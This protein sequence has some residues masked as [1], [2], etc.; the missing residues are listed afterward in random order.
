LKNTEAEYDKQ[1]KE[2]K[3]SKDKGNDFKVSQIEHKRNQALAKIRKEFAE[4]EEQI[5]AFYERINQI[6]GKL[7]V[8]TVISEDEYT[9]L[10]E[11]GLIFFEAMM[12]AEAVKRLLE[13]LDL[14]KE[15]RKLRMKADKEKGDKRAKT[16]RRIQYLEG[17]QNNTIQ[18]NLDGFE[19]FASITSR[20]KAN[21]SS[22]RR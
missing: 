5:D 10:I 7:K 14:Q 4:R 17:F 21:N 16:T 1:L 12:G 8:G 13:R 3:K 18:S 15:L 9:D 6:I 22:I 19:Y 20:I 2:I 11:R